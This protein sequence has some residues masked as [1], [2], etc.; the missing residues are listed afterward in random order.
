VTG[1]QYEKYVRAT[2]APPPDRWEGSTTCPPPLRD[3]P[4]FNVSWFEAMEY[5][6][7][8]GKRL[9]TEAQW[10]KA[11]RGVD[12]RL[13]PWGN[14]FERWRCN[15]RETSEK[16]GLRAGRRA[17]GASPY[18]CLD[19]AGN[20]WEWTLGREKPHE[21]ARIIRGGAAYN[22]PEELVTF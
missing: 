3:R 13:C 15:C 10:E 7:W 9:P 16:D 8:A 20:V 5:A 1:A 18:G 2:G 19:M 14:R 12:G 22:H 17:G 4:V 6:R 21:A 11:A